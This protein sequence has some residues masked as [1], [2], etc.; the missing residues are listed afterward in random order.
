MESLFLSKKIKKDYFV[1]ILHTWE[2]MSQNEIITQNTTRTKYTDKQILN[3]YGTSIDCV[4][5]TI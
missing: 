3:R 4:L 5:R 2:I 1:C